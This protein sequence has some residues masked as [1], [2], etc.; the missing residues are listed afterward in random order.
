MFE[1]TNK[2]DVEKK[3]FEIMN[4]QDVLA[5]ARIFDSRLID[6]IKNKGTEK[7]FEGSRLIY[8]QSRSELTKNIVI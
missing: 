6:Q 1:I 5:G 8:T 4:K 2:Q 7:V 3:V